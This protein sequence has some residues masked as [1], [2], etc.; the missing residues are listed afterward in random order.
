MLDAR[1]CQMSGN[2]EKQKIPQQVSDAHSRMQQHI[3]VHILPTLKYIQTNIT[4][5]I[6]QFQ[7]R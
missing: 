4:D 2:D 7:Q 5:G 6:C 3:L 1:K